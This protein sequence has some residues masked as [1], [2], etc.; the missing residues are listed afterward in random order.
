[1]LQIWNDNDALKLVSCPHGFISRDPVLF[2]ILLVQS[3]VS[4]KGIVNTSNSREIER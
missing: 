2:M 1:M 3:R 4:F